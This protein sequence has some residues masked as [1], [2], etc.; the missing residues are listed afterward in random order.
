MGEQVNV[1]TLVQPA[2]LVAEKVYRELVKLAGLKGT[3]VQKL[4]GNVSLK[5]SSPP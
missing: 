1:R 2:P 3:G 5:P 4:K